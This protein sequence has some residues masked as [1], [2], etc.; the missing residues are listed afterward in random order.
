[1]KHK[2]H[3]AGGLAIVALVSA[4]FAVDLHFDTLK[5]TE[6]EN[7]LKSFS[8]NDTEREAILKNL[9]VAAGC[10]E[11]LSEQ[12]VKHLREPNLICVLPGQNEAAIIVG[13]HFDHADEGDGVV[14]NWSGASLLPSLYEGLRVQARQHTFLFVAFAG[15]EKGDV[16]SEA[17]VR[18]M[19][20][21][22]VTRTKAM[23]NLECLGLGET[24]V[25][26][27]HSDPKLVAALNALANGL[28]LPLGAVNVERVGTSD[29]EQFANR[30]IP[31]ITIHSLT[32]DTLPILHSRKDKLDALHLDDYYETYR[33][34]SGYL[35]YLDTSLELADPS[36]HAVGR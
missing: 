26:Q 23:I 9:F 8:R 11:H 32:Q 24:K 18:N 20:N 36:G 12:A 10:A 22:D 21:Q 6:I 15:E 7:R 34:L 35:V 14:D 25:W 3:L 4:A 27:S 33:L 29:S 17:Y 30:K 2:P 31:R 16:G 5:Q 28:K 13:A 19:S 1:M